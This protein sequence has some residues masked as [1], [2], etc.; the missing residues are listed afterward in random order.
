MLAI[1]S[2]LLN[3][4]HH[5]SSRIYRTHNA[6]IGEYMDRTSLESRKKRSYVAFSLER[7][8][9]ERSL[10]YTHDRSYVRMY[11]NA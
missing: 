11:M 1:V 4:Y 8:F 2:M 9:S 3:I 10:D 5:N 6:I 7:S